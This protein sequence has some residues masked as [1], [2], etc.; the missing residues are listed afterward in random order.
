MPLR[1]WTAS[2]LETGRRRAW[3]LVRVITGW[4]LTIAGLV[5]IP[6]PVLPGFLLVIPG[7][8]LLAAESRWVRRLLRRMR[9][10]RLLRR[11]M[12]EAEKAGLRIEEEPDESDRPP[13]P[14]SG[15]PSA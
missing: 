12:R 7:V 10:H 15:P 2:D 5:L 3:S 13:P 8:A 11:A 1:W 6:V 4:I 9:D 14:S